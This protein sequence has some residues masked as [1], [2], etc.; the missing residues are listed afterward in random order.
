MAEIIKINF[1][2]RTTPITQAGL[3]KILVFTKEKAVAYMEGDEI[4]TFSGLTSSDEAYKSISAI[5]SQTSQTVALYGDLETLDVEASLTTVGGRD[6][7]FIVPVGFDTAEL[8]SISTWCA[9]NDR[10]MI[11]TPAYD[12]SVANIIALGTAMASENSGIFAHIGTPESAQVYLASGICGLLAPKDPG[13]ATWALKTPNTI[14]VNEYAPADETLLLAD[15][16]NIFTEEYGRGITQD[17]TATNGSY[18]DITRAKYWLRYRLQ[19]E[20]AL[21]FMNRDKVP[22]TVVGQ[23][24]IKNAIQKVINVADRMGILVEEKTAVLVPDPDVLLTNDKANRVW[25]GIEI[26]TTVQGAVHSIS[27]KIILSV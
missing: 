1:E 15:N 23:T 27:L 19:E 21:L 13:S 12:T 16:I 26:E 2:D 5:L 9:S 11:C 14:T 18:L 10:M 7:F 4:A 24:L 17:G 8:T 20:L 3:N 25:N 6:F 22:F